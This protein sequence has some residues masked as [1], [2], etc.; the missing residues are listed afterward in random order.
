MKKAHS[1][2]FLITDNKKNFLAIILFSAALLLAFESNILPWDTKSVWGGRWTLLVLGLP[3]LIYRYSGQMLVIDAYSKSISIAFSIFKI[4]VG[5]KNPTSL[6]AKEAFLLPKSLI[7]DHN[8][9]SLCVGEFREGESIFLPYKV[10]KSEIDEFESAELLLRDVSRKIKIPA[11]IYWS[12]VFKNQE[13][14]YKEG[15]QLDS[16]F[17]ER[18]FENNLKTG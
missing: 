16:P 4:Q 9:Y 2:S 7:K 12:H 10:L 6:F 5:Y 11:R 17:E 13:N 18:F 14:A 3:Y 15:P 1:I 8:Q